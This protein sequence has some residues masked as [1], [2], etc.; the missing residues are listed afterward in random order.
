MPLSG[1]RGSL[2]SVFI[3]AGRLGKPDRS[4]APLRFGS[5]VPFSLSLDDPGPVLAVKDPLRRS[6]PWTAPGKPRP[7]RSFYEEKGGAGVGFWVA[8]RGKMERPKDLADD[9]ERSGKSFASWFVSLTLGVEVRLLRGITSD[10]R[11]Q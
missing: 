6:A 4:G 1:P 2:S 7:A 5:G 8:E 9:A 3:P 11:P 10:R